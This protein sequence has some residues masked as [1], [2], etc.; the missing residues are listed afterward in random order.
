M[1]VY[2]RALA[3]LTSLDALAPERR[4][5]IAALV[6]EIIETQTGG[7]PLSAEELADLEA[8]LHAPGRV[9]SDEE[10]EAVFRTLLR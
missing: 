9:A 2:H 3:A 7:A 4:D 6:L 1:S 5:A 8:R 10:V